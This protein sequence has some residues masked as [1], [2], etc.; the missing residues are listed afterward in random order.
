MPRK[1]RSSKTRL[2]R[3]SIRVERREEVDWDKFA[4]AL[5]QFVKL[6]NS[7][8]DTTPSSKRQQSGKP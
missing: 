7:G 1:K 6:Q 4:W 5:L 3:V 2:E 8:T